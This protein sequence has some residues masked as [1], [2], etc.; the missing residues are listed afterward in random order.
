MMTKLNY[1][2]HMLIAAY[3]D[4]VKEEIEKTGD[5]EKVVKKHMQLLRSK[6]EEQSDGNKQ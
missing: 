6:L 3:L 2:Q 1:L 5:A 4:M